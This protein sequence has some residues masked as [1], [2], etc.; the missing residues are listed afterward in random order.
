MTESMEGISGFQTVRLG[1][2]PVIRQLIEEAGLVERIDRLS[3]VKKEDC[4]VSVGTRIAALIINQLSDRKP[5]SR[6]KH[7]MKTKMLNCCSAQASL[8]VI[9][10]M[11]RWDGP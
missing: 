5:S 7:S 6:S 9:S 11:M 4:Q 8:R 10:M 3:P 2:T 1:S